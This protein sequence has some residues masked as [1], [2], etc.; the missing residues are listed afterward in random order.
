MRSPRSETPLDRRTI[1]CPTCEA[2]VRVRSSSDEPAP[3]TR[4]C[5][6]CGVRFVLGRAMTTILGPDPAFAAGD[7]GPQNAE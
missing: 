6:A 5:P 2:T 1:P 4:S 3:T 7:V